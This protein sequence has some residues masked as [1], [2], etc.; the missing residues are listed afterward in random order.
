MAL[1]F[2]PPPGWPTPPK[3]FV[4]DNNWTPDPSW[5]KAPEGWVFWVEENVSGAT[6]PSASFAFN[7]AGE[8]QRTT[9]REANSNTG[10]LS[11]PTHTVPNVTDLNVVY[12]EIAKIPIFGKKKYVAQIQRTVSG[13]HDQIKHLNDQ[14]VILEEK[15]ENIKQNEELYNHLTSIGALPEM[16]RE[17]ELLERDILN[18]SRALA[19]QKKQLQRDYDSKMLALAKAQADE[20]RSFDESRRKEVATLNKTRA[21]LSEEISL[22]RRELGGFNDVLDL[23]HSGLYQYFN[24]AEE[25]VELKSELDSVRDRIKDMVKSKKAIV[26]KNAGF[27]FNNSVSEG[28][29]FVKD[30]T[31]LMLNAYNN[32]A[33]NAIVKSERTRDIELALSRLD[34]AKDKIEKMGTMMTMKVSPSYHQL[35]TKEIELAFKY[36]NKVKEEKE[37]EAARKA[38][39]REEEKIRREAEREIQKIADEEKR[40]RDLIAAAEAEREAEQERLR[41]EALNKEQKHYANVVE[42]LAHEAPEDPRIAEYKK[43]LDEL[44]QAKKK[45]NNQLANTKAGY[46]YVISNIG[47]FGDSVVKIGM[48]RRQEPRDRVKELGDASVPFLFDIHA[49]HFSHDA[50]SLEKAL[51]H[52]FKDRAVNKVNFRKEF[53]RVKPAEVRE[54][55]KELSNGALLEFTE[56]PIAEDFRASMLL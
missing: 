21:T 8:G 35:R 32:E 34:K 23:N 56:D 51:H 52:R 22:L 42:S 31:T 6:E 3:S 4:P 26:S 30:F 25:S 2:N 11:E 53:F 1:V 41:V 17:K 40:I 55:F 13:M 20:K 43:K 19:E 37:F 47:S 24:P 14:K 10:A 5:P 39:L 36:K 12:S 18:S 38:E 28:D 46:V 44:E 48:T 15:L 50:V 49:L 54:A 9:D 27:T 29:K 7:S 33:E 45:Q 16:Y